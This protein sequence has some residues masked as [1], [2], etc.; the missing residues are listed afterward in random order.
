MLNNILKR[1]DSHIIGRK[2]YGL[3][4]VILAVALVAIYV[5][6][7]GQE[8]IGKVTSLQ[9]STVVVSTPMTLAEAKRQYEE[10]HDLKSLLVY[11]NALD[12]TMLSMDSTRAELQKQFFRE[13]AKEAGAKYNINW[14]ILYGLWM[15]ESQVN[16]QAKGDGRVGEDGRIIPGSF[17]AFGLGQIHVRTAKTHY[18]PSMTAERLLDP[19]ENGLASAKVLR[20]YTDMFGG[21]IKYGIS[22][23]QQGPENTKS[24]YAKKQEPKNIS[25]VIDVLQNAAEVH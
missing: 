16:P 9:D 18:D 21:N 23:Y 5:L 13:L 25:Y 7:D 20:D 10:K 19:I 17:R 2:S 4:A 1:R 14:N 11:G 22:A 24:Q 15:R 3:I 12:V 8:L 6:T